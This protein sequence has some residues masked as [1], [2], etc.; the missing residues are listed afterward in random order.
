M[1]NK[2][3]RIGIVVSLFVFSHLVIAV[4]TIYISNGEKTFPQLDSSQWMLLFYAITASVALW[5]QSLLTT[6]YL[7]VQ[8]YG[9]KCLVKCLCGQAFVWFAVAMLMTALASAMRSA[10]PTVFVTYRSSWY[11][12]PYGLDA[13]LCFNANLVFKKLFI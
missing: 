9:D 1:K 4:A 11:F 2:K 8:G 3:D 5:A 7:S 13:A 12:F 6:R 10:E